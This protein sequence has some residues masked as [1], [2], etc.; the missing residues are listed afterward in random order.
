MH[1]ALYDRTDWSSFVRL[2]L[3]HLELLQR[4]LAER[5]RIPT[6]TLSMMLKGRRPLDPQDVEPI[7]NALELDAEGRVWFEALVD[8]DSRSERARRSA[9]AAIRSRLQQRSAADPDDDVAELQGDWTAMVVVELATCAGFRADP[10]W[11]AGKVVPPI[12]EAEA[13][14]AL[15]A[16][17]RVGM[18]VPRPDAGWDV[19]SVRTASSLPRDKTAHALRLRKSVRALLGRSTARL[20]ER[21]DGVATMALSEPRAELILARMRQMEQELVQLALDDPGPRNRVHFVG[22]QIF[23]ASD[24]TDTEAD[25]SISASSH[26]VPEKAPLSR[27]DRQ[28]RFLDRVLDG[29]DGHLTAKKWASLG[30]CSLPTA[31]RDLLDLVERG[32]LARN[33]GGSKNTSYRL[34]DGGRDAD[35]V[36]ASSGPS[37]GHR[38]DQSLS[39]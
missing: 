10:A 23:P 20:N 34:A 24:Y 33:P 28:R 18:L 19:V 29:F 22:M 32:V 9:Y 21:H 17:I 16:L 15:N 12:S 4:D 27:A 13:R 14:D 6:S 8:L 2:R 11:L 39:V 31:Q 30:K 37:N 35:G 26:G 38:R 5:L 1:D 25:E 3:E 36:R 7:A